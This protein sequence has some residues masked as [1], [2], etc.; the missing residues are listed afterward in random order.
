[1][2]SISRSSPSRNSVSTGSSGQRSSGSRN[3]FGVSIPT[4]TYSPNYN[5][6][7]GYWNDT[8]L[9]VYRLMSR[10]YFLNGYN[11]LWRYQQGDSPLTQ[12]SVQIAL[13]ECASASGGLLRLSDQLEHIVNQYESGELSQADFE[14]QVDQATKQIRKLSKKIRKDDFL[15][16]IDQR[17]KDKVPSFPEAAS[18]GGLRSLTRQLRLMA[19][20]VDRGLEMFNKEDMTRTVNVRELE[21]PSFDS[22]TKGID[23]LS[24]TISK[25]ARRL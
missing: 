14:R 24:K 21:Q 18:V 10:Y 7:W 2:P 15:D 8:N 20:E 3:G 1:M 12:H 23:R 13:Q 9:F 6:N 25:S 17:Q 22:L 5:W 11:Y 19:Y 16:Y 4:Q